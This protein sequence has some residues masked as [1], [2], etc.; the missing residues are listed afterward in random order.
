MCVFQTGLND[1]TSKVS[2][3]KRAFEEVSSISAER[4][5]GVESRE[6]AAEPRHSP[7]TGKGRIYVPLI[8]SLNFGDASKLIICNTPFYRQGGHIELIRFKEYYGMPSGHSLSIDAHF[9]GK[10]RTSL[11]ISRE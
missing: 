8:N 5:K 3:L 7:R 2:V 11:Y 6:H 9:S 10:K 1:N 4:K